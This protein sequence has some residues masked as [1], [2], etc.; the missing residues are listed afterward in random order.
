MK[1]VTLSTLALAF[2]LLLGGAV[3]AQST[4][5]KI[6]G[7]YVGPAKVVCKGGFF[8]AKVTLKITKQKGHVLKGT[9]ILEGFP[10]GEGGSGSITFNGVIMGDT[11]E[12]IIGTDTHGRATISGNTA[13]GYVHSIGDLGQIKTYNPFSMWFVVEKQ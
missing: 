4:A 12:M 9:A 11:L 1:K 5:P 10:P 6:L 3:H 13:E 7:T 8:D 2:V